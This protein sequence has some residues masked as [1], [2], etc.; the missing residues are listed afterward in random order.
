MAMSFN[1]AFYLENN[2]DVAA[3]IEAGLIPGAEWHFNNFGWQEGR[4]PNPFFDVSHYLSENTDVAEAGVNPLEHFLTFG[5]SEGRKPFADFVSRDEFDAET[6]LANNPDLEEAGIT[7]PE[8]LYAHFATFGFAEERPGAQTNDGESITEG[9]VVT[10]DDDDPDVEDPDVLDPDDDDDDD[11]ETDTD[12]DVF[13]PATFQ[14]LEDGDGNVTFGG[15]AIGTIEVAIDRDADTVVFAREGV[16]A[17]N[18][19]D[20]ATFVANFLVNENPENGGGT[21]SIGSP[22]TSTPGWDPNSTNELN[23]NQE[24]PGRIGQDVPYVSLDF[25]TGI[26]PGTVTLD[27]WNNTNSLAFFEIRIDGKETGSTTH[28]VTGDTIHTGGIS[29]DGIG[30]PDPVIRSIE[31][32][33]ESIVEVRLALGGERDWD[34]DWVEFKVGELQPGFDFI[35][36]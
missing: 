26:G 24:V 33:A 11:D 29:V 31:F 25:S 5:A 28:P 22:G 36:V 23:F 6:Y 32:E 19:I 21:V 16:T 9:R 34:F 18:S 14:V 30:N 4:N 12:D 20:Y 17:S 35:F 13:I 1:E 15:T 10:D 2:P 8:E 7:S 3:A 27:F